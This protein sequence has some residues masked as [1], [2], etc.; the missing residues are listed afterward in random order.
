VPPLPLDV[1]VPVVVVALDVLVGAPPLPVV[2][3][4]VVAV[5]LPVVADVVAP[6]VDPGAVESSEL[7]APTQPSHALDAI[8]TI[9]EIFMTSLLGSKRLHS[10]G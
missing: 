9:E 7:H 4:V 3:P 1:V 6:V 2:G 8:T 5:V 10:T